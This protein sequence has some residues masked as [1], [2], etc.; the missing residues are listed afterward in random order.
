MSP[1]LWVLCPLTEQDAHP[2]ALSL[3][4]KGCA[5]GAAVSALFYESS[6]RALR[7]AMGAGAQAVYIEAVPPDARWDDLA[8]AQALLPLITAHAPQMLWAPATVRGRALAP[9]LAALLGTGLTAD[10]TDLS[11]EGELLVSTRPAFSGSV[12]AKI[13]CEAARPQMATVRPGVFPE[14]SLIYP[15]HDRVYFHESPCRARILLRDFSPAPQADP[16]PQAKLIL[17]GGK[18]L[19]SREAF[20]QLEAL[21]ARIGAGVGAT[22]SAVDAGYAP[23]RC[24]I[25]QTGLCVH[26]D[27]Y[28]AVGVSGAVQHIAG[29]SGA[30]YVA[31]INP[32]PKAPI[33][34]YADYGII[35][36][37]EESLPRLLK[38]M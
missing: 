27:V 1:S 26:P 31:A 22:R 9:C 19:G 21:A 28:V 37:W 29:M 10:C 5:L 12:T 34:Q 16:L 13:L 11:L 3:I 23:Y 24:Q 15:C 2:A 7:Q 38:S 4:A 8:V 33:F 17:C 6:E 30:G 36:T 18:G 32:D 20:L 14:A 25:G 35:G